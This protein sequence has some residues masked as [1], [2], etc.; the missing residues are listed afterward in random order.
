MAGDLVPTAKAYL[1]Q[2]ALLAISPDVLCLL[3]QLGLDT[4]AELTPLCIKTPKAGCQMSGVALHRFDV[5]R[6][7]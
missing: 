7:S 1:V 4:D 2:G 3:D 6:T 5:S